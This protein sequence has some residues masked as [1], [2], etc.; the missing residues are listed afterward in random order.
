MAKINHMEMAEAVS[1]HPH[2]EIQKTLFGLSR[3]Y[4]YTPTGS[5]LSANVYEF[6]ADM[7]NRIEKMLN[8]KGVQLEKEIASIGHI[9]SVTIGNMRLD[10]CMS[11][12]G[13]FAALQLFRYFELMYH[14]VAPVKFFE[15]SEA[16]H[17]STLF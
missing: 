17:I 9:K 6:N 7:G 15:G 1:S 10:V 8:S 5:P 16:H 13:Q 3:K 4:I 2:I 11:L 14:P 12:D